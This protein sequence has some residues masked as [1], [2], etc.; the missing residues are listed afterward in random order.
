MTHRSG[1]DAAGPTVLVTGATG[2]LG[3]RL[4]HRLLSGGCRVRVLVRSA[5]KA[6]ALT[7]RGA[8]IVLGDITDR[9][10]VRRAVDDATVVYHLAGRLFVPGVPADEYYR[11]HVEGTT[12]LLSACR[13]AR[14]LRRF[15]HVSTTGVIGVTGDR[16][17]DEAAAIRP[18]NV[19]EATK[20]HAELAVRES[21]LDGFPAVIARPGLVYGPGDLHLLPFFRSVLRRRFRPVG[22][23]PVWLHPI[24]VDDLTDALLLCGH[25]RGAPGQCFNLAGREPVS[26]A[27]LA[28]AIA[29]AGGTRPAA[30]HIPLTLA[31][32]VA[33]A[34]DRLPIALRRSAPLTRSRLEF[35]THSRV[36]DVAKAARVLDFAARTDLSTGT[37][38]TIAWYRRSGYMP[39]ARRA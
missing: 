6:R 15:V 35:L 39:A 20:A 30:G 27:G 13:D 25:H 4:V 10:N 29:R 19:Y 8:E 7:D 38:E 12:A 37:A 21:W 16:P 23:R 28:A 14:T 31:R 18:T 34:G 26:L 11:T 5:A 22:S 9:D 2:F 3:A 36:Y 33:W 24:Y 32:A 17:A 1:D